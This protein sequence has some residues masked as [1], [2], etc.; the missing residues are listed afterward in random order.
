MEIIKHGK[1]FKEVEDKHGRITCQEC[2][3]VFEYGNDDISVTHT[4]FLDTPK[5][6]E[7]VMCP[8]CYKMYKIGE[9]VDYNFL[10]N[11]TISSPIDISSLK[12]S[13]SDNNEGRISSNF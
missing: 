7:M 13:I 3:C 6:E 12:N 2:G 9:Q 4:Y 1:N 11:S 10:R 8:E 5:I